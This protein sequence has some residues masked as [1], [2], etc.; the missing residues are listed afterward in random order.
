MPQADSNRMSVRFFEEAA[1][2]KFETANPKFTELRLTGESLA[3][4]TDV[5]ASQ[6]LRSDRQVVD[7]IRTGVSS[8]GNINGELSYG[9]YDDFYEKVL[10]SAGWSTVQT[11]GPAATFAVTAGSGNYVIADSGSGFGSFAVGQW[12]Y[13]SGFADAA[14][15]GY[16]KISVQA[17]G[18]ITVTHNGNGVTEA[19]AATVTITMGPQVLNGTTLA[20]YNVEKEF[21][22]LS[23]EFEQHAGMGIDT[24]NRDVTVDGIVTDSFGFI[25]AISQ[26]ATSTLGDGSPTAAPTEAVMNA[27]DDVVGVLESGAQYDVTALNWAL[28]NS[29]RARLQVGTL[30]AISL[31]VG[32]VGITGGHTAYYATKAIM[33]KYLG[34]VL[35]DL[36]FVFARGANAYVVDFPSVKYSSGQRVAGGINTD[37]L[38]EMQWT[39]FMDATELVSMRVAR[40]AGVIV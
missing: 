40:F 5:I 1:F 31:G 32:T 38:A 21:E 20:T 15:N 2:G 19:A 7:L 16:A 17:A 9:A 25:G 12:I 6:E 29:L 23:N 22:D 10:Q 27:I 14:N 39:A 33:D 24:W 11:A 35:T 18:S 8:G 34:D 30:G 4:A 36:V 13:I 3:Q 28:A 26:S 37:I